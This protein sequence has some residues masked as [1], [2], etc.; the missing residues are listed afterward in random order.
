MNIVPDWVLVALQTLPFLVT[1]FVLRSLLFKPLLAY[2]DERREAIDGA[3][4]EAERLRVRLAEARALWEQRLAEARA[5]GALHRA[6]IV[7]EANAQR[8]ALVDG[9]R[10][11]AERLVGAALEDLG[12]ARAEASARI[13]ADAVQLADALA[14][15]IL[16]RP[17][18]RA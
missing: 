5:E 17:L 13:E 18:V 8:Q 16:G 12:R 4:V 9:A 14:E 11:E 2:L 3:R 1:F 15:R 10:G 7:A 6:S